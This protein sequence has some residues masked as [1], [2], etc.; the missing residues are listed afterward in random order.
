[1]SEEGVQA[2]VRPAPGWLALA[3]VQ[4]KF[5]WRWVS[6]V[7]TQRGAAIGS[8]EPTGGLIHR[9][10]SDCIP[11]RTFDCTHWE[12]TLDRGKPIAL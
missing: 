7:P 8:P 2:K 3:W 9:C 11:G 5:D 1:V 12:R 10:S 6:A 4:T